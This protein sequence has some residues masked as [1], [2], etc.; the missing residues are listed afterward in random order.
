MNQHVAYL[1]VN[2]AN[3]NLVVDDISTQ[4]V[5]KVPENTII[6]KIFAN[7]DNIMLGYSS[8]TRTLGVFP[9]NMIKHLHLNNSDFFDETKELYSSDFNGYT[10]RDKIF[11]CIKDENLESN[12]L[13][14]YCEYNN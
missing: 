3:S 14:I 7:N 10:D 6:K 8:N 13:I 5:F 1:P 9:T 11:N 2:I 12:K 4:N